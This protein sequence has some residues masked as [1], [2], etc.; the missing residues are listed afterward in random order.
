MLALFGSFWVAPAGLMKLCSKRMCTSIR[1]SVSRFSGS[2]PFVALPSAD[3]VPT[4]QSRST[5][6]TRS[7]PPRNGRP[8]R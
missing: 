7:C 8:C 6:T 3:A 4:D 5:R 2:T 1:P